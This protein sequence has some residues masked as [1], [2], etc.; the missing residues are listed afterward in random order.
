M[1]NAVFLSV[2]VVVHIQTFWILAKST[3]LLLCYNLRYLPKAS[4][5]FWILGKST[6]LLL[7]YKIPFVIF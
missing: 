2:L 6:S 5:I 1:S 3:T 7:C 4:V